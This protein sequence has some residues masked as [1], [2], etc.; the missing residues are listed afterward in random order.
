MQFLQIAQVSIVQRVWVEQFRAC[1]NPNRIQKIRSAKIIEPRTRWIIEEAY[2]DHQLFEGQTFDEE[3][4]SFFGPTASQSILLG[5]QIEQLA[6]H[7]IGQVVYLEFDPIS[8][9]F[10]KLV[11]QLN[12]SMMTLKICFKK[13]SLNNY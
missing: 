9:Q 10:L 5:Q 8:W 13:L 7:Q 1:K 6:Q 12:S 3:E 2:V 11:I 4:K